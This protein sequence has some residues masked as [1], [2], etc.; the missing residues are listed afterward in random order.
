MTALKGCDR[1]DEG[2]AGC[3]ASGDIGELRW[4]EEGVEGGIE[5]GVPRMTMTR[6]VKEE[7]R[8]DE[9]KEEREEEVD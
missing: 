8:D 4:E 6:R 7:G 9:G 1:A 2:S 5:R 3:G